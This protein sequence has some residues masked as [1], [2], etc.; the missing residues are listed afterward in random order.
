M[1]HINVTFFGSVFLIFGTL[2]AEAHS[3]IPRSEGDLKEDIQDIVSS[4]SRAELPTR[5][6]QRVCYV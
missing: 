1:D 3:N 6:E 4:I 2:E 5:N